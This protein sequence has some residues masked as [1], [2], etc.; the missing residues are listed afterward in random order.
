MLS[1]TNKIKYYDRLIS[2]NNKFFNILG[3][4][5]MKYRF[6][7]FR[8]VCNSL[9]KQR[10]PLPGFARFVTEEMTARRSK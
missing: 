9:Q 10:S 7:D 2:N 3:A 8:R 6:L 5:Y 4:G 1:T